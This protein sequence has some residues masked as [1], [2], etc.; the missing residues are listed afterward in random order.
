SL[1]GIACRF[2]MFRAAGARVVAGVS[3]S[4]ISPVLQ[5]GSEEGLVYAAAVGLWAGM[6]YEQ[7]SALFRAE[8][9]SVGYVI[10]SLSNILITVGATVLLVVV[11]DEGPLGVLVGNFIGTLCVYFVLLG[12]LRY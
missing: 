4:Q 6:N 9:R 5:L 2:R 10:A 8:E 3:A 12:Y 1:A 11:L 7:M